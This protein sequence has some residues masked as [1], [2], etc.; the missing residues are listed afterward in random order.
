MQCNAMQYNA[1]QYNTIQ[2]NTPGFDTGI[3]LKEVVVCVSC[4]KNEGLSIL[5]LVVI[6]L[7]SWKAAEVSVLKLQTQ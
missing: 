2:Y 4:L 7:S 6:S 5:M 1:I 3:I